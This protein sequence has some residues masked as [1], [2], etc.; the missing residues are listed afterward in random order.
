MVD[1][2][3]FDTDNVRHVVHHHLHTIHV[4]PVEEDNSDWFLLLCRSVIILSAAYLCWVYC[5]PYIAKLL[6]KEEIEIE[7]E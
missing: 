3:D 6:G 7:T 1:D 2:R 4:H 5:E